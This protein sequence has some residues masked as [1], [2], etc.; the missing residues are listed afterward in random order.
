MQYLWSAFEVCVFL[1]FLEYLCKV[2]GVFMK[3]FFNC[4]VFVEYL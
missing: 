4:A 3:C 2:Y 1:F